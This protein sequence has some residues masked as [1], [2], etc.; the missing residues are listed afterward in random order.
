VINGNP[1]DKG[2]YL[3]DGIYPFWSTFVKIVC[4][5][6][7]EKYKRFAKE[8]EADKKDMER[9]FGVLQSKVCYCLVL[10]WNMN[11]REDVKCDDCLCDHE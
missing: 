3:V 6:A 11:H 4:K 7:D 10:C 2:Y 1:Y 8:Q 9:A 5:H